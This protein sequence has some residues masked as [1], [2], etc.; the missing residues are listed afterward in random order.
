M[1]Q[2]LFVCLS[3]Q[4]MFGEVHCVCGETDLCVKSPADCNCRR[5][6]D[7]VRSGCNVVLRGQNCGPRHI[8]SAERL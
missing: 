8:L 6:Y 7:R 1:F 4:S 5:K 3:S 2:S